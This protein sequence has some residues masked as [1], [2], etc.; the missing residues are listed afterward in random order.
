MLVSPNALNAD[1]E[2]IQPK[3]PALAIFAIQEKSVWV[4]VEPVQFVR[5]GSGAMTPE[6]LAKVVRQGHMPHLAVALVLF[7]TE[8]HIVRRNRPR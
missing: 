6:R 4:V 3:A 2:R 5:L 1:S 7:A 8:V